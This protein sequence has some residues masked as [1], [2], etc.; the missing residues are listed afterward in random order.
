MKIINIFLASSIDEFKNERNELQCFINDVAEDFRDRYDTDI[1][2]QRCEKVD[3]RYVKGRSQDEFNELIK[4]S[5]ICIFLFFTKAGEYTIEEF[6]VARKAFEASENGKPKIYTYFKTIDNVS[7]DKSVTDFM[8]ELDKNLKHFYQTFS[9]IDTVKLRV[10][11]NLKMQEMDFISVEFEDGK[12]IVD[13]KETLDLSNV[14]EFAN[15]GV[16][17]QLNEEL[18]SID[19]EYFEMKPIYATGKADEAFCKKY[20]E[21]AARKQNL[22]EQIEE[23]QK[24]IFNISLRMCDDEVHGK[25]TLRQKEAYRLFELGDLEGANNILDFD[26][27]SNDY[28]RRKE[29]RKQEQIKEARIFVRESIT[30]IEVL[31]AMTNYKGRFDDIE[32]IYDTIIPE[33]FE[34]KIELSILLKYIIFLKEQNSFEKALELI[35]KFACFDEFIEDEFRYAITH[36]TAAIYKELGNSK[37]EL[38]YYNKALNMLEKIYDK[39]PYK[40]C[41]NKSELLLDLG[42]YYKTIGN[43]KTSKKYLISAWN[44]TN[45]FPQVFR[46]SE[47]LISISIG[48]ANLYLDECNH[49]RAIDY[50]YSAYEKIK[51]LE[52]N[53]RNDYYQVVCCTQIGFIYSMCKKYNDS[54]VYFLSALRLLEELY[55]INPK[56]YCINLIC[57]YDNLGNT[58]RYLKEYTNAH[59]ELNKARR[60]INTDILS[61]FKF[62]QYLANNYNSFG[63]LF[64]DEGNVIEAEKQFLKAIKI[65]KKLYE[66]N[67]EIF[68]ED[69]ASCYF[70]LAELKNDKIYYNISYE[71]AIQQ[72][73]KL[74]CNQIIERYKK[75]F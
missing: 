61:Q 67:K 65:Y 22:I 5:E 21:I 60:L 73:S 44:L 34:I 15:N 29:I 50:I 12:C 45:E 68:L 18:L 64:C 23:L 63:S 47:E 16:L 40:F 69:L 8:S 75:Y 48:L 70:N 26:E 42:L 2:V 46:N 56:Q 27:I 13:G 35:N 19:K 30:K 58:Y 28:Q 43:F 66:T 39:Q 74:Y 4:N 49:T 71:L 20:A 72:P 7:V 62:S 59:N 11:L 41:L 36:I 31:T 33:I 53:E 3:P 55:E 17:K 6:E 54:K 9:H 51:N 24:K 1:R 25:V 52:S 10:L 32:N 14:A 38:Q 57:A 37:K